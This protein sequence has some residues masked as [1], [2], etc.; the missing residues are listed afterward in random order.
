MLRIVICMNEIVQYA[1]MV[2]LPRV[3]LFEE[4]RG[5]PLTLKS[6]GPFRNRPQYRQSTE[7]SGFVIW[8]FGVDGCHGVAVIL[9]ARRFG[10]STGILV[11]SSDCSQI[12]FLS[13]GSL[14]RTQTLL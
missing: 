3:H 13:L 9:V 12:E 11:Q 8:I 7:Q 5:L 14:R 6:F 1:W 2:R 10:S 4:L